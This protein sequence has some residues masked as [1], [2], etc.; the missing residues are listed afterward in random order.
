MVWGRTGLFC[1]VFFL[2][3]LCSASSQAKDGDADTQVK[4]YNFNVGE[5]VYVTMP[6]GKEVVAVVRGKISSTKYYVRKYKSDLQGTVNK[7]Y[8]R[9]IPASEVEDVKAKY[10]S[11][12]SD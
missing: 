9:P 12:L 4:E 5:Y 2:I 10:H 8:M 6:N 11:P 7:K 1:L 3:G